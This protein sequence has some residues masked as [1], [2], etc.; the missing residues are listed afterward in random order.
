MIGDLYIQD[1]TDALESVS[2]VMVKVGGDKR[3]PLLQ[4][5]I[6]DGIHERQT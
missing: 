5:H 3:V 2:A 6:T 4:T 1:L